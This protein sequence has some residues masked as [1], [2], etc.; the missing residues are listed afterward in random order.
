MPIQDFDKNLIKD[1]FTVR[2]ASE[3]NVQIAEK[4]EIRPDVV[5]VSFKN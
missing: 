1:G 5:Q 2:L 4:G 3:F